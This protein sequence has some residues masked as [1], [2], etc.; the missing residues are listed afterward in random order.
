MVLVGL[1]AIVW[2]VRGIGEGDVLGGVEQVW[3]V[4]GRASCVGFLGLVALYF[5][6]YLLD[7]FAW[8][9]LLPPGSGVSYGAL[10]KASLAGGTVNT[11]TP[12]GNLGEPVK[13]LLLRGYGDPRTLASTLLVWNGLYLI[14][15][16]ALVACCAVPIALF[17]QPRPLLLVLYLAGALVTAA[18]VLGLWLAV[19]WKAVSRI[20]RRIAERNRSGHGGRVHS[21]VE[22][23]ENAVHDQVRSRPRGLVWAMTWLLASRALSNFLTVGIAW[24]LGLEL[25]F[26]AVVY[27]QLLNQ[28]LN[29]VFAFIPGRLGVAEGY[30]EMTIRE[31]GGLPGEGLGVAVV[32]RCLQVI[33]LVV[34]TVLIYRAVPSGAR[35][36]DPRSE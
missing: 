16:A 13:I 4:L 2:V 20:L 9:T 35:E 15:N 24:S 7:A 10:L 12:S 29:V 34:G 3:R 17:L 21:F 8:R 22:A 6:S 26:W 36:S 1:L 33:A 31:L 25:S 28:A 30:T 5:S 18:P 23:V 19:R 14:A 27:V 11:F 32:S